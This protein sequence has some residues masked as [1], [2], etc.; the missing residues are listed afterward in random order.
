MRGHV[1]VHTDTII[2]IKK[3]KGKNYECLLGSILLSQS[4]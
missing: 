4:A 3:H 2:P 1:F